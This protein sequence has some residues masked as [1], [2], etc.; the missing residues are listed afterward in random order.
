MSEAGSDKAMAKRH[1]NHNTSSNAATS[2]ATHSPLSPP[3]TVHDNSYEITQSEM[4]VSPVQA[5]FAEPPKVDNL[6]IEV[7]PI[8]PLLK[9]TTDSAPEY[10]VNTMAQ[11][12]MHFGGNDMFLDFDPTKNM[13][14]PSL[15]FGD[16]FE[17]T[18]WLNYGT[19]QE[20]TPF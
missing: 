20:F 18:S 6:T 19:E 7:Q 4:H 8:D 14:T 16:A 13:P 17:P 2:I 11:P 10:P 1:R 15:L 3:A 12:E 9:M 5:Q